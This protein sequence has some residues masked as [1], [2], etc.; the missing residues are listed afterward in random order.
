MWRPVILGLIV[1]LLLGFIDS[2]SYAVL[3]FTTAE[4]SILIIVPL[5]IFALKYL[6]VRFTLH[7]VIIASATALGVDFTTTITSGMFLTYGFLNH[8]SDKLSFFGLNI[9][10]PRHLF[11]LSQNLIEARSMWPYILGAYASIGGV[12]ILYVLRH[13]YFE[14]ERLMYPLG[15]AASILTEALNSINWT[16][17]LILLSIFAGFAL[18]LIYMLNP[19]H[20]DYTDKISAVLPNAPLA[21][22]FIP[23]SLGIA[24]IIP[25]RPL[26]AISLASLAVNVLLIPLLAKL[27]GSSML[28]ALNYDDALLSISIYQISMVFG[29]TVILST[30]LLRRFIRELPRTLTLL[31]RTHTESTLLY[32]GIALVL[33][34]FIAGIILAV[35]YNILIA[36]PILI[37]S[38]ILFVI[39]ITTYAYVVGDVGFG[40][41]STLPLNTVIYTVSGIRYV[42]IYALTDPYLG[43][44]M[45]QVAAGI[46]GNI[47]RMSRLL[48]S[49]LIK[50]VA[51]F[52]LGIIVGAPVT[53]I[54]GNILVHAYGFDSQAMPM[55]RWIPT[56]TLTSVVVSGKISSVDPLY[57]AVGVILSLIILTALRSQVYIAA[58]IVGILIPPDIAFTFLIASFIKETFFR[59][60]A[61]AYEKMLTVS[62]LYTFGCGIAVVFYTLLTLAYGW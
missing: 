50:A 12:F 29:M 53:Y 11:D 36:V 2:Y 37:L 49:S 40:A 55:D 35:E 19:F 46:A 25:T 18:Q 51:S 16:S 9:E 21:F 6:Q 15:T 42:D 24:L 58:S 7:D 10:V 27:L 31:L 62:A 1:G 48:G 52:I 43:I 61:E 41:Q 39:S 45:P 57:I 60:G 22:S 54:Y 5:V 33:T 47:L 3:G 56:A 38:A 34:P 32:L 8:L 14:R 23:I 28:P 26:R 17:K 20:F 30:I 59:L 4:I 13:Y 44:P